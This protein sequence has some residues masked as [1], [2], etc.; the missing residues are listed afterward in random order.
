MRNIKEEASRCMLCMDAPCSWSCKSADPAKAV[1]AIRFDNEK[2]A[3]YLFSWCS[4][5]ELAEAEEA[6]IHYDRP[7]RLREMAAALASG[8]LA[9]DSER[10]APSLEI[11]FCGLRC[12]NI[13][14]SLHRQRSAPIMRWWLAPSRP[15]GLES[16]TRP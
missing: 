7:I 13:R 11:D 12:E 4:Q 9:R 5:D 3:A 1:R 16:S 8:N 6:C 10:P 14:S 15:G 2:L